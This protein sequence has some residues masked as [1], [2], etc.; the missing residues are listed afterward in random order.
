MSELRTT[1][2]CVTVLS[3]VRQQ[4]APSLIEHEL[5]VGDPAVVRGTIFELPRT[6][7]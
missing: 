2:G 6:G 5:S 1:V 3:L 4:L 7:P